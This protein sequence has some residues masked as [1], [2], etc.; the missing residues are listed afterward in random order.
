[1]SSDEES[2]SGEEATSEEEEVVV[3]KKK[4]KAKKK[5]DPNKPKRNMSAFFLYSKPC[6]LE[7]E[8]WQ[9][10]QTWLQEYKALPEKEKKQWEDLR[11]SRESQDRAPL[12]PSLVTLSCTSPCPS[13]RD[14]PTVSSPSREEPCTLEREFWQCAKILSQEYKA[15]PEK[16][17]KQWEDLAE[18]DKER[19]K[20]EMEDYEPPSDDSDDDGKRR[21]KK[22]KDPNA[23][24]RNQ[25]AFFIYSNTHRATVK[26]NNPDASFG[27]I[28]KIIS[29]LFKALSEKERSKY[30]KLAL[31][32]K[33]RYQREMAAYKGA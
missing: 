29:K 23:P 13:R 20:R 19:Y 1:M 16:E 30:D 33:A 28:A 22:K 31:E 25:S 11:E 8:F 17:K 12:K 27:D 32:D 14:L 15:L 10:H 4:R 5:K 18:K 6:T 21:K 26:Q 9:C 3:P 7:R 24:K 2:I